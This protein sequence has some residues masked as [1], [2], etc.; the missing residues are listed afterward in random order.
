[1]LVD[2]QENPLAALDPM[3]Q[4]LAVIGG[5]GSAGATR[6]AKGFYQISHFSFD[7]LYPGQLVDRWRDFKLEDEDRWDL[8]N[9]LVEMGI[10]TYGVCDTPEQF[11]QRY[12]QKLDNLPEKVVVSFTVVRKDEQSPEGGW[13]WHKWG[14]Y[15]GEKKP[16]HEYLYDEGPEIT[17]ATCFHVYQVKDE[18]FRARGANG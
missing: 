16:Q 8:P 17:Q 14:Q 4:I 6:L 2:I 15:V 9:K 12:K 18:T 13:R 5:G 7:H 1:M 10:D 11:I 3:R